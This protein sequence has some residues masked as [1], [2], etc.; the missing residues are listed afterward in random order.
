MMESKEMKQLIRQGTAIV[1]FAA[2]IGI[3]ANLVN[4]VGYVLVTKESL[5]LKKLVTV[6][7]KEARIKFESGA[8]VIVD[9]RSSREY[10]ES[11][12]EGAINIPAQPDSASLAGIRE[13]MAELDGPKE[14]LIY[15]DASCDSDEVLA[16]RIISM[17]YD[18]NVYV[19]DE[20]LPAWKDG[21]NPVRKTEEI[22]GEGK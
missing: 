1:V 18:R 2:A 13:H 17:G 16:R 20:G 5:S 7:V 22:T 4:P 6:T 9:A 19:L 8:A 15:C 10:D 3:M 21:G 14:L 12:I 11:H